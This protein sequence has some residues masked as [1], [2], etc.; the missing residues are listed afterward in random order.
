MLQ[1]LKETYQIIRENY[2]KILIISILS[3][4]L[5][6]TIIILVVGLQICN[7]KFNEKILI[8]LLIFFLIT[9][10][11]KFISYEMSI[12]LLKIA[13]ILI[14]LITIFLRKFCMRKE[15]RMDIVYIVSI[16]IILL[17]SFY[18]PSQILIKIFKY[19]LILFI[20]FLFILIQNKKIKDL[21][22]LKGI[23]KMLIV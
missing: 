7:F 12:D 18:Y 15:E 22:Y 5:S 17:L 23:L 6:S 8:N 19:Y 11:I 2:L 14:I 10:L 3:L 1:E 21:L 16:S 20:F 13:I 9:I 4:F